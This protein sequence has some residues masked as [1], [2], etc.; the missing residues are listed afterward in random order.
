MRQDKQQNPLTKEYY[1]TSKTQC[2]FF[3]KPNIVVKIASNKPKLNRL[4]CT[5][6]VMGSVLNETR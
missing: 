3:E 6:L 2:L 1:F 5:S 4:Y